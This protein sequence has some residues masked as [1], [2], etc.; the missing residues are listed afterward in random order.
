MVVFCAPR[1]V[2]RKS[3]TKCAT[4][5]EM[6]K[7][8]KSPHFQTVLNYLINRLSGIT[9]SPND[10]FSLRL[11]LYLEVKSCFSQRP[12]SCIQLMLKVPL[13][14]AGKWF[15]ALMQKE[16]F[17]SH[18]AWSLFSESHSQSWGEGTESV[19]ELKGCLDL[20]VERE[21]RY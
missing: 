11:F 15:T 2:A 14:G 6:R 18:H 9:K 1:D 19:L 20:Q 3:N 21:L 13:T 7:K 5:F 16:V 8:K 17:F 10:C 12:K 4:Y